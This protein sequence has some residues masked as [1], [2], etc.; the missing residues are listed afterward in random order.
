MPSWV[1]DAVMAT[2]TLR[3][4]ALQQSPGD[5]LIGVMQPVISA[6]L[7]GSPW[8]TEQIQFNK[9]SWPGRLQLAMRL[10]A[11][12]PDTVV[13]LAN[14]LWTAV[15]ARLSGAKRTLGYARDGRGWLLSDTLPALKKDGKFT[16]VPAIDYYLQLAGKLGCDTSSR[17]MELTVEG[18]DRQLAE[19]LYSRIGF[20]RE[21]PLIVINSSGAWGVAKIWPADHVEQ[22]AKRIVENHQWQV[23]LHCG[24]GER[25]SAD[26]VAS[27]INHP[28]VQSMGQA[29][30]LPLGLTKAVMELATVVVSTDSGP[31]HIAVALDRPVVGLFGPTD[32]AWTR[33]YNLEETEI[34]L[35]LAC[36][37]CWQKSC[38]LVHN[39]CMRDLGVEA[40]Y[41]GVVAAFL[42]QRAR[43]AA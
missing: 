35:Q 43:L 38:P 42:N 18:R 5:S 32:A 19:Q 27:R 23:L 26:A 36:R 28:R 33:T 20:N 22:L 39:R 21:R 4:L 15:V 29:T 13:L 40:V 25:E 12:K 17:R 30:E 2:P 3:A 31:R 10:R 6:V 14:S 8:F 16:P 34:G 1:G 9:R 41:G 11:A 37:G 24:P 7:S